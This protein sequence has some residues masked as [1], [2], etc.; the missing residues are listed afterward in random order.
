M[1]VTISYVYAGG[2]RLDYNDD[3]TEEGA[4]CWIDGFDAGFAAKYDKNRA[5]ECFETGQDQY[6]PSWGF[7]CTDAGHTEKEC[8]DAI[9]NPVDLGTHAQLEE[10][11]SCYDSGFKDGN[12][13]LAFNKDRNNACSEYSDQGLQQKGDLFGDS[14]AHTIKQYNRAKIILISAY[15]L[16]NALVRELEEQ[17]ASLVDY[18][19][20]TEEEEE[21]KEESD[22]PSLCSGSNGVN[23][24][25][26]CD[27]YNATERTEYYPNATKGCWDRTTP[28][29]TFCKAFDALTD[30]YEYCRDSKE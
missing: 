1:V 4:Y 9:N 7:A 12:S 25:P 3:S 15:D 20:E 27:K 28:P 30:T 13:S 26:F 21:C 19:D 18:K 8:G 17:I 24:K 23:G 11:N 29:I 22:Y 10:Q 6:N 5:E 16:D 2:P 14:V